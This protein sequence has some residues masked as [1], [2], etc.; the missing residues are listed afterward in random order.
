MFEFLGL[1]RGKVAKVSEPKL[2]PVAVP[3]N[4]Q[5]RSPS[6]QREMIRLAL[7]G[8]LRRH[9][10]PSQWLGCEVNAVALH[11]VPDGVLIQLV[12]H[13]WHDGL[14][15]FGPALQSE[16]IK[17]IQL[18]DKSFSEPE[19]LLVWKFAPGCG[20]PNSKLPD[21]EFWALRA[22]KEDTL[23]P[24][25]PVAPAVKFDL[26]KSDLDDDADSD[27]GFAPTQIR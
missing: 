13:Q 4:E 24:A 10:I 2:S 21:P 16:L 20:N 7:S 9:G 17:E 18:F 11:G 22:E 26:P 19:S 27:N 12:I 15:Q 3:S 1:G 23:P 25:D 6:K 14:M 8:V 5:S